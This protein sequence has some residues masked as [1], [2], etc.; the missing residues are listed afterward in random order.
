MWIYT[1]SRILGVIAIK[2]CY[3]C[4]SYLYGVFCSLLQTDYPTNLSVGTQ[5][6]HHTHV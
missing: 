5:V 4:C 6:S 1:Y 3:M 2:N